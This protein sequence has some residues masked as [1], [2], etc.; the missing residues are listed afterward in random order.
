[1]LLLE[2]AH[3]DGG[4]HALAAEHEVGHAQRRFGLA[5]ARRAH[6]QEYADG[7]L[8]VL[9]ARLAGANARAEDLHDVILALDALSHLLFELEQRCRLV[10]HH[11]ADGNARPVRDHLGHDVGRDLD[12]DQRVLALQFLEIGQRRIKVLL[13]RADIGLGLDFGFLLGLVLDLELGFLLRRRGRFGLGLLAAQRLPRGLKHLSADV[14]HLLGRGLFFLPAFRER[15]G[16]VLEARD[17]LF[18]LRNHVLQAVL[19]RAL[20]ALVGGELAL[21][22]LDAALEVLQ[23]RRLGGQRHLHARGTGVHQVDAFVGVLATGNVARTKL[24]AGGERV[25][26]DQHTVGLLVTVAQAAQH[27]HRDGF[28]GLVELDELEAAG[29]RGILL[30]VLLVLAPGRSGDGTQLAARQGGLEQLPGVAGARRAARADERVG[31]VNEQDDGLGRRLDLVDHV[32]EAVFELAFDACAGLQEREVKAHEFHAAQAVRHVAFN[33]AQSQALDH[34]RL[35]HAGVAHANRVVLSAARQDIDHLA[36]FRITA[37]HGVKLALARA[38]GEVG[39]ELGQSAFASDALLGP[40]VFTDLLAAVTRLVALDGAARDIEQLSLE[41]AA[42]D[43]LEGRQ[44]VPR[45][46]ALGVAQQG[47]QQGAAADLGHAVIHAGDQPGVLEPVQQ[48][49]R[50]HGARRVAGAESSMAAPRAF[51]TMPTSRPKCL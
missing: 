11:L 29:Q 22:G 33:N 30:E 36:D 4:H 17:A 10:L 43:S 37:K 24:R 51:C 48:H 44:V 18:A 35:A 42:L 20:V 12:L 26:A 25:I 5:C 32:L 23:L 19:A 46:V 47:E 50:E 39:A 38:A 34:G 41:L 40:A 31:F 49:G 6:Q 9:E 1:M 28:V 15:G 13:E 14:E 7:C 27:G 3:V 45:C 8:G 2:L 16:F 21:D